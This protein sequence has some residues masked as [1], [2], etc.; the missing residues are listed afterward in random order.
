M[1]IY[2]IFTYYIFKYKYSTNFWCIVFWN[3]IWIY[4]IHF[5][6]TVSSAI[7]Q[8]SFLPDL[9]LP[10]CLPLVTSDL[11]LQSKKLF[12][13][14]SVHLFVWFLN[15]PYK[16]NQM[17]FV[18]LCLVCFDLFCQG[19]TWQHSGSLWWYAQWSPGGIENI[20]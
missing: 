9:L 13:F 11:I 6:W 5:L 4:Y 17:V 12:S 19:H 3:N 14:Y 2:F 8:R 10:H 15:M 20:V 7:I 18:F 1:F 16:W